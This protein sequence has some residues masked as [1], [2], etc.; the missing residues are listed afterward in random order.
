MESAVWINLNLVLVIVLVTNITWSEEG[1]F[2][3]E[4]FWVQPKETQPDLERKFQPEHSKTSLYTVALDLQ[5]TVN[6]F[7]LTC[8]TYLLEI[9]S[10]GALVRNVCIWFWLEVAAQNTYDFRLEEDN[11]KAADSAANEFSHVVVMGNAASHEMRNI[12]VG[13]GQVKLEL[14]QVKVLQQG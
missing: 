11:T 7:V 2:M 13:I 1:I 9:C 4:E 12:D 5:N 3:V 8:W 6:W 14:P 10:L